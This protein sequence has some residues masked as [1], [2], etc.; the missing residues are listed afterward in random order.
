MK[1]E[2][3]PFAPE[4]VDQVRWL[5]EFF[6]YLHA[7][8]GRT[9]VIHVPGE[10]IAT[11]AFELLAS[12]FA[13]LAGLGVRL[14]L[15]HGI[16]AQIDQRL[17]QLA[18][19]PRL[20]NNL[21]IT[22]DAA[23]ACVID[24]A[25]SV[26]A[27]IEARLSV[28]LSATP[29]T[30]A[31]MRVVSGNFVT[32]RPVGVRGGIDF[33]FTG[34]VRRIDRQRLQ[35]LLKHDNLVLISPLGYSPNGAIFNLQAEHLAAAIATE[36][37]AEKL[38][39]LTEQAIQD[40]VTLA[41]LSEVTTDEALAWAAGQSLTPAFR[42]A[43]SAA[44]DACQHGVERAHLVPCAAQGGLLVELFSRKGFGT[45]I[46][47]TPF[48]QLRPASID[49]VHGILQLIQPL[50]AQGLL[51]PRSREW[52][53]IRIPDYIVLDLD[54]LIIGT[55]ALHHTET[56]ACAL[57]AS[58]A[59]HPEYRRHGRAGRLLGYLE[60]KARR[61][62]VRELFVLSTQTMDWF[63]ERG[64]HSVTLHDLPDSLRDLYRPERNAKILCKTLH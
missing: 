29:E 16:R 60:N 21:R 45:L 31:R 52:L 7:H 64:Y 1:T 15:V 27:S 9:F 8:R 25:G 46:S 2:S 39:F 54:G 35:V 3:A 58:M 61:H 62:G 12:D 38:I 4:L 37:A 28:S 24:A 13:L 18:I 55:A 14:V 20:V 53:E 22:D 34:E 50:E 5:R 23:L 40:P 11:S 49:D 44:I 56:D 47:Q 59:V 51:A 41:R 17:N 10:L 57:I 19:S 32:A 43:L 36:L 48:E 42:Q 33:G 63:S 26:R 6:P 30:R